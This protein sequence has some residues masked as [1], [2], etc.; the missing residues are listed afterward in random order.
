V[1]IAASGAGPT[2]TALFPAITS[3]VLS[4]LKTQT[5]EAGPL[6]ILFLLIRQDSRHQTVRS[7]AARLL[8]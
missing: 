8:H 4:M 5:T 7:S 2:A 3:T 6:D 1:E